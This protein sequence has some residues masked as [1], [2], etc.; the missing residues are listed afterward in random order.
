MFEK[1]RESPYKTNSYHSLEH[2]KQN[3]IR[4]LELVFTFYAGKGNKY[5]YLELPEKYFT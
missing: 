3:T 1:Q 5:N 2:N 4:Q